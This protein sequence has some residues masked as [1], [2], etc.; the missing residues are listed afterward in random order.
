[1]FKEF[2]NS[3]PVSTTSYG[4]RGVCTV[5][6]A[7]LIAKQLGTTV[8]LHAGSHLGA[9]L[10]GGPIPWDDDIDMSLPYKYKDR[11]FSACNEYGELYPGIRLKCMMGWN[12]IKVFFDG[13][14]FTQLT[15]NGWSSPFID[16][17]FYKSARGRVWE[18]LPNGK[19]ARSI[20]FPADTFLRPRKYYFG[21]IMSYAPQVSVVRKWYDFNKCVIPSWDHR[22]EYRS[23]YKGNPLVSCRMLKNYGMPFVTT[24]NESY[25]VLS[26]DN[27]RTHTRYEVA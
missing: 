15:R 20:T 23:S 24:L 4:A 27:G 9:A 2:H 12:A 14:N 19:R 13:A 8:F 18:V 11:Y 5:K 10:H 6:T 7:Q 17:S 3:I 1:L 26:N 21:G 25:V 16:I 22:I